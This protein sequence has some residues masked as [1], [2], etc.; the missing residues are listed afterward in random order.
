[1]SVRLKRRKPPRMGL[2]EPTRINCP[3]HLQ[4]VRGLQCVV[5]DGRCDGKMHAHH[6]RL[7]SRAGLGRKPGD[8]R[9]VPLCATHHQL[10]HDG[11]QATFQARH[12]VDLNDVADR[13]WAMSRH[14][15]EYRLEREQEE[16]ESR[17]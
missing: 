3:A 17:K 10:L 7:G 1:M 15:K 5:S 13:C 9:A 16:R 14:G 12:C 11:G 2:R 8:D 6:V 4:F